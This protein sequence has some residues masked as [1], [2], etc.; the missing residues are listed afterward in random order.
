MQWK[1]LTLVEWKEKKQTL[2]FWAE[3]KSYTGAAGNN[4][5]KL[6]GDFATH[7]HTLPFSNADGKRC[8]HNKNI[9]NLRF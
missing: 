6:L 3:V 7:L 1:N 2:A 8:R 4:P 5:Y 9:W